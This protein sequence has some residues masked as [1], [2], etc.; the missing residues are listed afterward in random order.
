[1]YSHARRG[2]AALYPKWQEA[3]EMR[4][5]QTD[6]NP[7]MELAA[8]QRLIREV[9]QKLAAGQRDQVAPALLAQFSAAQNDGIR[10]GPKIGERVPDFTLTD[11]AGNQRSLADL[12]GPQ[13]LYLIFVRSADW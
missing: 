3:G 9:G 1:M 4:S 7:T 12:S 8:K 10:T 13:G 6:A 5:G 11:Q 2:A